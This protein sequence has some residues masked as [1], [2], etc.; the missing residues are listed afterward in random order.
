MSESVSLAGSSLSRPTMP[1]TRHVHCLCILSY[2]PVNE[3]CTVR[4]CKATAHDQSIEDRPHS[5][6]A[7]FASRWKVSALVAIRPL[8]RS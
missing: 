7:T 4:T 2:Y 5:L 6:F 8:H 3:A 1:D